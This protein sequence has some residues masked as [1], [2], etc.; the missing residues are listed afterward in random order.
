MDRSFKGLY[1]GGDGEDGDDAGGSGFGGNAF[2]RIFGWQYT[3][4]LIAEQE[5]ISVKA[6]FE[7]STIEALNTMAYMKAKS[8]YDREQMKKIRN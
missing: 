1:D 6:V 7:M 5:N 4:R 2:I 3:A 8:S